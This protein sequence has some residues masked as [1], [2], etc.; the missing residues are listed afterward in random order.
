MP[1][2][3][4]KAG[5]ELKAGDYIVYGHNLGRCAALRYGM[6]VD[7]YEPKENWRSEKR[8]HIRVRGVDAEGWSAA[9]G[10]QLLSKD[11]TLQFGD[12]VLRIS[13]SQM[14]DP[15]LKLLRDWDLEK[16]GLK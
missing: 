6:I 11:S 16:R 13:N 3:K 8:I 12:R 2:L 5:H 4:D 1:V 9:K 14:P 7:I 15:V 10:P